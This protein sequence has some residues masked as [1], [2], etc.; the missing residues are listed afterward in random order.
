MA[1]KKKKFTPASGKIVSK[2]VAPKV[3][4]VK[5]VVP[6]VAVKPK[7]SYERFRRMAGSLHAQRLTCKWFIEQ[8]IF[9]KDIGLP[10]GVE[11][12]APLTVYDSENGQLSKT[13]CRQYVAVFESLNATIL[14]LLEQWVLTHGD[15][16]P[17]DVKFLDEFKLPDEV[18]T[19]L[20]DK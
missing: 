5:P 1:T 14:T 13:L 17:E 12:A 9:G 3:E 18:L 19:L 6:I 10:I 2:P 20:A 11:T 7:V 4:V 16:L 8:H 15:L